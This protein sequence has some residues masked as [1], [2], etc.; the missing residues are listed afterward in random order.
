[1]SQLFSQL[2]IDWHLLL[3]QAV[4]FLLLL[5]ILRFVVYKPLLTLLHKRR[6]RIEEGLTKADEADKRLGEVD[7]IG[8]EK[9]R[10]AENSALRILKKTEIDAKDLEARLI[11]EAK[12]KEDA[13]LK[14]AEFALRAQEE[15]S[16]KAIEQ[17][18]AAFIR[19]AIA[20]TVELSPNAID[21]K[22]IAK[23]VEEVRRGQ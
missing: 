14:N 22:L 2:G 20:K 12:R 13:E 9:I 7:R 18:A 23:A 3:S 19:A 4:N 8:K 11:T 17:E 15:A 5:A 16:R 10:E 1:M 21:E 6:E